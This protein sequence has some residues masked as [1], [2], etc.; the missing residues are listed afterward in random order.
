MTHARELVLLVLF[1]VAVTVV[2]VAV[3][4]AVLLVRAAHQTSPE[5]ALFGGPPPAS[6]IDERFEV[7]EFPH[8][9]EVECLEFS[10]DGKYL[11]AGSKETGRTREGS[12]NGDLT[13]WEVR[14]GREVKTLRM[15]QW[16]KTLSFG[17][18]GKTLAV[19]CSSANYNT[20]ADAFFGFVQCP[21]QVYLFDFPSM[22]EVKV[23]EFEGLV[24]A[25][26]LSPDGR[27]IAVMRTPD[28]KSKGPFEVV[29]FG[30]D[31]P[32][33]KVVIA[34]KHLPLLYSSDGT[35]LIL[36]DEYRER[37]D[38][39]ERSYDLK[40]FDARTGKFKRKVEAVKRM[41]DDSIEMTS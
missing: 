4:A 40:V 12:W 33:E 18:A 28:V 2:A 35:D 39:P 20:R 30:L 11:V 23:F 14:T 22:R 3:V 29:L 36:G 41:P 26:R 34:K 9:G 38:R 13:V 19:A 10:P 21:G 15:P 31:A 17:P 7:T 27:R 6:I 1:A 8:A 5:L 37:P 24:E 16:V 32:A 25:A